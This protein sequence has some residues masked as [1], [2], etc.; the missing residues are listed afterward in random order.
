MLYLIRCNSISMPPKRRDSVERKTIRDP[1]PEA[2]SKRV[3]PPKPPKPKAAGDRIAKDQEECGKNGTDAN[4]Q[5][6]HDFSHGMCIFCDFEDPDHHETKAR[7]SAKANRDKAIDDEDV[8]D[9][10]KLP[11]AAERKAGRSVTLEEKAA[12]LKKV[13]VFTDEDIAAHILD[14][15][16]T[17]RSRIRAIID[18]DISEE[19][20]DHHFREYAEPE[21]AGDALE[22]LVDL[23]GGQVEEAVINHDD[24]GLTD[25][26][27]GHSETYLELLK[28]E[29]I[30]MQ[31]E[32]HHRTSHI[33]R[34]N[35]DDAH[36]P[37]VITDSLVK[38]KKCDKTI[39]NDIIDTKW[40]VAF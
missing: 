14:L 19:I 2:K 22:F 24:Y 6:G 10:S 30:E 21:H 38:C 31:K 23:L 34:A 16:G 7:K 36:I 15:S 12:L 11:T 25:R 3:H 35:D 32:K 13:T 29:A 40:R 1:S 5:P 4:G 39:R 8:H 20:V 27:F 33:C 26:S 9:D 28:Y 17:L 18:F 37:K